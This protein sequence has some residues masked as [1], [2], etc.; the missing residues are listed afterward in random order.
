MRC[1]RRA[2]HRIANAPLLH[3]LLRLVGS[4]VLCRARRGGASAGEPPASL[5]CVPSVRA[6]ALG[7]R[8]GARAA[9]HA[10]A[11]LF[12]TTAVDAD[13]LEGFGGS[14]RSLLILCVLGLLG[15]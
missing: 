14:R 6:A 1:V 5:V 8:V 7:S 4:Q 11:A 10:A 3:G 13:A 15:G 2:W 12:A 9:A